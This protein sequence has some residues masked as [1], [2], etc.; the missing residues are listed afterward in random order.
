MTI[1]STTAEYYEILDIGHLR[2]NFVEILFER[3]EESII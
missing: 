2:D 1:K 3:L